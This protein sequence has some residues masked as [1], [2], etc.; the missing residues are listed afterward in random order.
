[1]H[2]S[3]PISLFAEAMNEASVSHVKGDQRGWITN[4]AKWATV[5]EPQ[6]SGAPKSPRF[7]VSWFL[8]V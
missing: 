6:I 4:Q 8:V 3:T 7:T 5:L 1:M 2:V